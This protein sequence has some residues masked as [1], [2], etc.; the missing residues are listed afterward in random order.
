MSLSLEVTVKKGGMMGT[1]WGGGGLRFLKVLPGTSDE[2][3]IKISG[4]TMNVSIGPGLPS[5]TSNITIILLNLSLLY[6][7]VYKRINFV[8]LI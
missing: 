6:C 2:A 1:P 3:V 5:T 7:T 4:K 8:R